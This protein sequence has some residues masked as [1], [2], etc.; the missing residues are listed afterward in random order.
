MLEQLGRR[1]ELRH[2]RIEDFL[3]P[4]DPYVFQDLS[5]KF[6]LILSALSEMGVKSTDGHTLGFTNGKLGWLR[7][8]SEFGFRES[9]IHGWTATDETAQYEAELNAIE[10]AFEN[11]RKLRFDLPGLPATEILI[12][13][14]FAH[15]PTL[16]TEVGIKLG[17]YDFTISNTWSDQIEKTA[18]RCRK[19]SLGAERYAT[20]DYTNNTWVS[21][22][23]GQRSLVDSSV[24]DALEATKRN[25]HELNR[26]LKIRNGSLEDSQEII[27]IWLNLVMAS[28]L[29]ASERILN[30][31]TEEEF[32]RYKK[33][34]AKGLLTPG[35]YLGLLLKRSRL[36]KEDQSR[37]LLALEANTD[38]VLTPLGEVKA[39]FG[40]RNSSIKGTPTR[41]L[42][43]KTSAKGQ[44]DSLLRHWR[45][46]AAEHAKAN[47]NDIVILE[48]LLT[49]TWSDYLTN[50]RP[51]ITK[52]VHFPEN[53]I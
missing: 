24:Y 22:E 52:G 23:I 15:D 46:V 45:T 50:I 34:I 1:A 47:L 20:F 39:I 49:S 10:S 36:S 3:E 38:F 29:T 32:E 19:R 7:A 12:S 42:I 28:S 17:V 48:K 21:L 6:L 31:F 2:P 35:E 26:A 51:L 11:P 9:V 41:L 44:V 43:P 8:G 33:D 53:G 27:N 25:M 30:P 14:R 40:I 5:G 16:H 37:M 18:V 13:S 4:L